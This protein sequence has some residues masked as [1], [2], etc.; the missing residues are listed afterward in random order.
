MNQE[1]TLGHAIKA[2][3]KLSVN[4]RRIGRE[5]RSEPRFITRRK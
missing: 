4:A 1:G 5:S 3:E 2:L